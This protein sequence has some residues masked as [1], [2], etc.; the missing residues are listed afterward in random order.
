MDG[1]LLETILGFAPEAADAINK[2][3]HKPKNG[4]LLALIMASQ[5]KLLR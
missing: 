1:P 4:E 2:L 5:S 3:R